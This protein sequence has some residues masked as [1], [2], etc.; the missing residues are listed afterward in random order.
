M[1]FIMITIAATIIFTNNNTIIST[2]TNINIKTK[3][4]RGAYQVFVERT[5]NNVLFTYISL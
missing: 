3:H 2:P 4:P 5:N 1:K